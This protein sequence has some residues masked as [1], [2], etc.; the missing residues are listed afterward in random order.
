[1]TTP[2][3]PRPWT[4]ADVDA[5][6]E[7]SEAEIKAALEES[8]GAARALLADRA[9]TLVA[10]LT[11]A[12]RDSICLEEQLR[13]QGASAADIESVR[14]NRDRIMTAAGRIFAVALKAEI[15]D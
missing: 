9:S 1:V 7:Q 15:S 11:A 6:T 12:A 3:N 13:D 5:F 8:P 10:A 4:A 14:H 2:E